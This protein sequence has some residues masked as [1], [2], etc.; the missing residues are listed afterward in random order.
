MDISVVALSS[1]VPATAARD[2]VTEEP[3][4]LSCFFLRQRKERS[5]AE[6]LAFDYVPVYSFPWSD[7]LV[8][9]VLVEAYV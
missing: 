6:P 2:I 8:S 9:L 3:L 7:W 5:M 4:S 1:G